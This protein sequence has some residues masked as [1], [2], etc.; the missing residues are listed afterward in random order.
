MHPKGKVKRRDFIAM[1][2]AASLVGRV[3]LRVVPCL[4]IWMQNNGWCLC[5]VPRSL[6]LIQLSSDLTMLRYE[7]YSKE[8]KKSIDWVLDFTTV[9]S[10]RHGLPLQPIK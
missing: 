6:C 8:Q 3:S 9:T 7:Y 10:I 5:H 1:V 4:S 2:G